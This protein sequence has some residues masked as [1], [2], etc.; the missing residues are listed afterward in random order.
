MEFLDEVDTEPYKYF[1]SSL[2]RVYDY[3]AII[4]TDR[5][6]NEK[7]Y[8]DSIKKLEKECNCDEYKH[9]KSQEDEEEEEEEEE[10]KEENEENEKEEKEEKE[11]EENEEEENE[12]EKEEVKLLLKDKYIE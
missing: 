3:F 1:K 9:E 10:E 5:K 4:F 8:E 12:E 2:N 7:K 11:E 6:K